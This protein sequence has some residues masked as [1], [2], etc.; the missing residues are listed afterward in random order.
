[1]RDKLEVE[2]K[3]IPES[4]VGEK[5]VVVGNKVLKVTK[6]ILAHIQAI[7]GTGKVELEDVVNKVNALLRE[8]A[9]TNNTLPWHTTVEIG[10]GTQEDESRWTTSKIGEECTEQ[11]VLTTMTE[12]LTSV[13]G[14][15][16]DMK[17]TWMEDKK[18]VRMLMPA[19]L[20][21]VAR[22]RR[23]IGKK[24]REE[25][26]DIKTGEAKKLVEKVVMWEGARRQVQK[27]DMNKIG[28]FKHS[29]PP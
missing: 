8:K 15:K 17:N 1:M 9:I 23:D 7:D 18:A 13:F 19:E 25:N 27:M 21:K 16:G 3:V 22:G 10:K 29:P 11:E 2:G 6:I 4:K 5:R 12:C 28:E 26:K 24:W 14:A 20:S